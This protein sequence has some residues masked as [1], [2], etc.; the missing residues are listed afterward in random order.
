MSVLLPSIEATVRG[1]GEL[2]ENRR[3]VSINIYT[4]EIF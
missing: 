3:G 4:Y 1:D 2:N